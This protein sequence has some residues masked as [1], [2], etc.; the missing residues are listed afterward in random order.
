MICSHTACY[1]LTHNE[2]NLKDYQIKMIIDSGVSYDYY[3]AFINKYFNKLSMIAV[4]GSHG[5]TTSC[6]MLKTI[7]DDSTYLIGDGS[8]NKGNNNLFIFEACE[9]RDTFL[10]YRPY[11]GLVLNIDYDHP[12]YFNNLVDVE[13][14]FN[15]ACNNSKYIIAREDLKIKSDKKI[16][17]FYLP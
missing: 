7:L 3:P 12:D 10:N 14:S 11:I 1:G 16:S 8:S 6:T 5:K 2:R 9:Y 13:K 17:R 4:S 15:K